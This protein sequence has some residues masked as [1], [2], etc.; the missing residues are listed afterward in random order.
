MLRLVFLVVHLVAVLVLTVVIYAASL[1]EDLLLLCLLLEALNLC[2]YQFAQAGQY[3]VQC[4]E[5]IP[6]ANCIFSFVHFVQSLDDNLSS[7][8][9]LIPP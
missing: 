2:F 4:I 7:H 8:A 5:S 3:F 6:E 9:I 1:H